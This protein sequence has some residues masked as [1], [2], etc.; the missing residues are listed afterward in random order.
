MFCQEKSPPGRL[1]LE[2]LE[3]GQKGNKGASSCCLESH[4]TEPFQALA[5]AGVAALGVGLGARICL[6]TYR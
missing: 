4:Y 2:V 1:V 5:L 3:K 6:G